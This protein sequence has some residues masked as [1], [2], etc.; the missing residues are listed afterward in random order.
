MRNFNLKIKLDDGKVINYKTMT[1]VDTTVTEITST[2]SEDAKYIIL[3]Q[4]NG[5][6]TLVNARHTVYINVAEDTDPA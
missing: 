5:S 3:K 4:P 6:D 2:L 1:S